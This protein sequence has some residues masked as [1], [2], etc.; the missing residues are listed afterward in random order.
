VVW[1]YRGVQ[2]KESFRTLADAREAQGKRRLSGEK[3]P[4]SKETFAQYAATWLDTYRGRTSRG[5]SDTTRRD[6]R[7]SIETY[8]IPFLGRQRLSD[9]EPPD[10]RELIRHLEG[11]GLR[12]GSIRKNL[13]PL[14]ALFATAYEDG[15]IPSNPTQG[16][17][18]MVAVD[19]DAGRKAKAMTR[20]E[21][22]LVL[23]AL[24]DDWRPFFTFLAQTG[25]RISEAIAV[26]WADVDLGTQPRVS[27]ER[28]NYRGTVKRLKSAHS[29][30]TIPLSA[31]MV[32]T[33]RERR[34]QSYRG[35]DAPVWTTPDRKLTGG[36]V[37]PGTAINAR[38]L[39]RRVLDPA[40]G[41]L[42]LGWVGFHTFRHTCASLLFSGG[43][44]V[45][46]VQEWL[47]HADPGFTLRTYVHLLDEGLGSA[48]F[49][50]A[51]AVPAGSAVG[52]N[53]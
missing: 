45:K 24:T 40:T 49:L 10:V 43:K 38:N 11:K 19:E 53:Q 36:G 14:K 25:L 15:A 52:P 47:G 22:G 46:Q 9:I 23:S 3:R 33:L 31:G 37:L 1:R 51:V 21:L 35:E 13:A 48:D 27:V 20:V 30:R 26:T 34:A 12:A 41:P 17:R 29:R 44:D 50:D 7:R 6:Y 5:F 28:Q 42:G 8:A 32:A 39:R 18:V 2:H 16:L 4:R